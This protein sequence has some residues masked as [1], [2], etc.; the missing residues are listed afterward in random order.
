MKALLL[1]AHGSRRQASNQE[2]V[3]LVDA[4]RVATSDHFD[5]VEA[6]FL[7]LATPDIPTAIGNCVDAGAEEMVLVP[8]F[9]AAGSHVVEDLP[10]F[11]EQAKQAY[12]HCQFQLTAHIG[13]ASTM[14]DLVKSLAV[15]KEKW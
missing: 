8:Y 6:A 1:I 3:A 15:G 11:L 10:R 7:E 13:V 14:I 2:V 12:P 9:L 5:R 4:I